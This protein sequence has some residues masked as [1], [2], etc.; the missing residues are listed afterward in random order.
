METNMATENPCKSTSVSQ[1][2]IL[3]CLPGCIF[4]ISLGQR[5]HWDFVNDEYQHVIGRA[6]DQALRHLQEAPAERLSSQEQ[7]LRTALEDLSKTPGEVTLDV[8]LPQKDGRSLYMRGHLRSTR[9]E[10]GVT[11]V[12]GQAFDI[13]SLAKQEEALRIQAEE[14]RIVLAQSGKAMYRYI[15]QGRRGVLPEHVSQ[16]FDVPTQIDDLPRYPLDNGHIAPESVDAWLGFFDAIDRGEKTGSADVVMCLKPDAKCR[17]RM[18]FVSIADHQGIPASAIVT[19]EN[20]TLQYEHERL[21]A[22][23]I[24]A[25]LQ[26]AQKVFPEI[27]ALNLTQN[28]YRIIRHYE[29]TTLNTP[30]TGCIDD[31]IDLRCSAL[32]VKDREAFLNT[33]SRQSLMKAM[34]RGEDT[35]QL[36]YRRLDKQGQAYWMETI[37][38][39]VRNPFD[40]DVLLITLSRNVDEQKAEEAMLRQELHF[41]AEELRLTMSQMGK[42]V[43]RYDIPTSTLTVP[44]SYAEKHGISLVNP[45]YPESLKVARAAYPETRKII[46]DFYSSIRQG[47]P[48]GSCEFKA[49]DQHGTICWTKLEFATIFDDKN[50]PLRA[51]IIA[52]DVTTAHDQTAENTQLR[53][54][55]RLLRIIAQH[56]DR[57]VCYYDVATQTSRP[58][59]EETCQACVIPHLCERS[60][61]SL[62]DCGDILPESLPPLRN[63]FQEIHNGQAR[64]EIKIHAN[65]IHQEHRWFS[66][67]YTTIYNEARKPVAALISHRDITHQYERELA[68]LRY[69]QS[70]ESDNG[71]ALGLIEVDLT[72]DCIEKQRGSMVPP[73]ADATGQSW[74]E[75]ARQMVARKLLKE[76][77]PEGLRSFSREFLITQY[78]DGNYQL[79]HIWQMRFRGG[80]LGWVQTK[81]QL[82]ADPYTDHIRALIR[83]TDVTDEQEKQL[84]VQNRALRDGMTGLLNRATCEERIREQ[85]EDNQTKN[86]I[87]VLLDLDDLK[88]INDTFGHEQGDRAIWG[89]AE[90]LKTHFRDGDIIGRIGGDE[91]LVFLSGAAGNEE[92]IALSLSTLL[93]KLANLSVG[94]QDEQKIHCSIGC[95][96]QRWGKDSFSSLYQRADLALYHVK[97]NG[98]NN[99]AFYSPEMDQSDYQFRAQKLLSLRSTKKFELAEL[100]HLLNAISSFYQLVLSVNI[101]INDYYLMEESNDGVFSKVPTFGVLDDFVDLTTSRIH[102]GDVEAFTDCLSREALLRAYEAG[103]KSL[104]FTFR[105]LDQGEYRWTEAI[106]IFYTNE[107][108]DVCDFTLVRWASEREQELELLRLQKVLELAVAST[109]EYICLISPDTRRYSMFGAGIQNA[110][111]ISQE[112]VYDQVIQ[113]LRERYI[114]PEKWDTYCQEASL[115]T[116]MT[117]MQSNDGHYTYQ[118]IMPDGLRE[119][120]FH[121][122]EPSHTKLLMTVRQL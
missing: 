51:V 111:G 47:I 77:L 59:S 1:A 109:F 53:E 44:F 40:D 107:N 98:K 21:Q 68:Y 62:L 36:T 69:I 6:D 57:I 100:Q 82:V 61:S 11:R 28:T 16:E 73:G 92:S 30:K 22:L 27:I 81:L 25:L 45:N 58:W 91:F 29:P 55:E 79:E 118:Y 80:K 10:D 15:L 60:L 83:L 13:T 84:A 3:K 34:D 4:C 20:I 96:T 37:G 113:S 74:S 89:I 32:A 12:Y 56:S 121:W 78:A 115:D 33:L 108:G 66:L 99:F 50:T 39:R 103:E 23:D 65:T 90:T 112:G 64:G 14:T 2:S 5:W 87:L 19:Y 76:D 41:R 93:R 105:F 9:D 97:R 104:R 18:Q 88:S 119:V 95:A 85:M 106:A 49:L 120:S 48:S 42:T 75:F 110:H 52:E 116:V 46:L 86:G 101:S 17:Y 38:M 72:T 54:N 70:A 117:Q 114:Q 24:H 35:V 102:P 122:Y 7:M 63:M 71:K 94:K 67:K 8:V 31:M 43:C 26:A